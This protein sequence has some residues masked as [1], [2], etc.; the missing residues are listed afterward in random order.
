M[1]DNARQKWPKLNSNED[2]THRL[3]S[4][5]SRRRQF[6]RYREEHVQKQSKPLRDDDKTLPETMPTTFVSGEEGKSKGTFSY[7]MF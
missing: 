1:M 4:A 2:L 3:G 6:F 5:N 7:S